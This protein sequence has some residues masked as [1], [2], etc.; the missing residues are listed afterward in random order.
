[1]RSRFIRKYYYKVVN[2]HAFVDDLN[3]LKETNRFFNW[4][5][6]YTKIYERDTSWEE[7][8]D[9]DVETSA[10]SGSIS[11][12][13]FG[14]KFQSHLIRKSAFHLVRVYSPLSARNNE[15]VT[16]HMKLEKV[17]ITGLSLLHEKDEY[18]MDGYYGKLDPEES[19]FYK[20]FSPP[21]SSYYISHGRDISSLDL[22]YLAYKK[23]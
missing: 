10:L 9:Y 20:S 2:D 22:R 15:N 11:S 23:R 13:Y 19:F 21:D 8:G 1:M 14:Q 17:S 5:R 18:D 16:F 12:A 7:H 4:Y 3:K 6:G